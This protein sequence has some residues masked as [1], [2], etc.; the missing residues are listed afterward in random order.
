MA[1]HPFDHLLSSCIDP[2]SCEW[3]A[4]RNACKTLSVESGTFFRA[5]GDELQVAA[6]YGVSPFYL[7]QAKF[8]LS[9][10]ICGWVATHRETAVIN[11]VSK[12]PRFN[13]E[14][15]HITQFK[16]LSVLAAPVLSDGRLLGV[17]ELV[18]RDKP[19]SK[20]DAHQLEKIAAQSAAR[21]Q[22]LGR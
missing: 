12:D 13:G 17:I 10:G 16:T 14:V 20:A 3:Q 4:V 9:M 1:D 19:F 2:E 8:P 6:S 22:A 5:V 11:D 21:M 18:N 7:A 15:D